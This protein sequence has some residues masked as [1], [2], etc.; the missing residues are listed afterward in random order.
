MRL[1]KILLLVVC[2]LPLIIVT[3]DCADSSLEVARPEKIRSKRLVVYD[4]ETYAELADLWEAYYSQFPSE[5]AYANWMYAARYAQWDDYEELLEKGLRKYPANPVLLYLAGIKKHGSADNEEAIT[6]LERAVTLDPSYIDPWFSLVVNYMIRDD[7]QQTDVALQR[8]LESG[9]I[10]E[11]VMDYSYNM[12]LALDRDAILIT[13]GDNDTYPGWILTRLLNH[14]PDVII[15]NRSL[16]NT[17]WYPLYVI[18]EGVPRFITSDELEKL[19]DS[20]KPP[21]SEI[22]IPRIIDAAIKEGRPVYF[23]HTLTPTEMVLRYRQD[24]EML[25]LVALITPPSEQYKISLERTIRTWLEDFRTAGMDSW[26][27]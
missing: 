5:D 25:G 14:R 22:L 12:L 9:A 26:S 6:Y 19:R 1:T 23:S 24:G 16:L 11:E 10:A 20:T 8:L 27:L 15:V 4:V 3:Q 2:A 7:H 18:R 13:N 21:Y 17:D